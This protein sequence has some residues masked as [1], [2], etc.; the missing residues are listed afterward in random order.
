MQVLKRCAHR[1]LVVKTE[2]D[3]CS[4]VV[5]SGC[6]KKGPKKHSYLLALIAFAMQTVDQHPRRKK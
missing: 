4:W 5:C 1:Q 3:R 6:K 2:R